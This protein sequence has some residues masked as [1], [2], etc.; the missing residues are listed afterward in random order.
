MPSCA[1]CFGLIG[2]SENF[3][4]SD[5]WLLSANCRQEK[6]WRMSRDPEEVNK[7]TESTYKVREV[8]LKT[9]VTTC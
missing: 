7:L 9:N 4:E 3:D 6:G 8:T 2:R 5:Y 1:S